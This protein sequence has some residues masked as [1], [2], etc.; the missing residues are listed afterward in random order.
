[1]NIRQ[2]NSCENRA[3]V[4]I[5]FF[6]LT[7]TYIYIYYNIHIRFLVFRIPDDIHQ[8]FRIKIF[9]RLISHIIHVY[10]S[11]NIPSYEYTEGREC[12]KLLSER[13]FYNIFHSKIR[14]KI[15]I[16]L[17]FFFAFLYS[18]EWFVSKAAPVVPYLPRRLYSRDRTKRVRLHTRH[19]VQTDARG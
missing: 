15:G 17:F 2:Y 19:R 10:R 1:M 16:Y 11:H 18:Y 3:D 8:G 14:I 13:D 5:F 7:I 6:S 4:L 9:S 12:R